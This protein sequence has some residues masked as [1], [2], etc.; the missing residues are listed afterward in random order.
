[1]YMYMY[2]YMCVL[3]AAFV[4]VLQSYTPHTYIHTQALLMAGSALSRVHADVRGISREQAM[5]IANYVQ[6]SL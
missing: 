4:V 3:N 6:R 5:R 2:M 1:M